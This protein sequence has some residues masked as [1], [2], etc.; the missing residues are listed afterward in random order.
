MWRS[1]PPEPMISS[2]DSVPLEPVLPDPI[3]RLKQ[4]TLI[5]KT[6]VVK[7]EVNGDQ[8][9]VVKGRIEG[10]ISLPG[11]TI[12]VRHEGRV[13][14]DMLAKVIRIEGTVEGNLQGE[15]QILLCRSANVRGNLTASRVVLEDECRFRGGIRMTGGGEPA[16]E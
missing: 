1:V 10:N 14:G 7:G 12:T 15:E 8:D 13:K 6:L 9:L 5:G 11:R 3:D 4:R 2:K 16:A